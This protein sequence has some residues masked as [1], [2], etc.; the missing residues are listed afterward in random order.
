MATEADRYYYRQMNKEEQGAYHAMREGFL[1]LS[2][3][4]IVPALPM[5]TLASIFFRLRLDEPWIFYVET[6][7][8]R[9]AQGA[10]SMQLIP[11]YIYDRKKIPEHQKALK[12]RVARLV[13]QAAGLK[14]DQ[15]KELFIHDFICEHVTYD[16]LKKSYSHEITGPLQ[17]GVSVCE[18]IAKTVKVLCDELKI[19]CIIALCDSDPEHGYK[20]RHV[21][22]VIKIQGKWYHMDATFDNSLGRYGMK[23]YDYFNLDDK[24]NFRDHRPVMHP[25]PAC[26]DGASFYY[27]VNRLSLTKIEDVEKRLQTAIRKK[28]AHYIFHWRGGYLTKEVLLEIVKKAE[29][30]ASAKDKYLTMSFNWPQAVIAFHLYD[31]ASELPERILAEQADESDAEEKSEQT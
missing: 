26:T 28:Q 18:G 14:S 25:V 2:Q 20:Y 17:Q 19:P 29:E 13:R 21:W 22:N 10:D 8:C 15:E 9:H 11:S 24:W 23:R 31:S 30:V 1:S 16:K 12:S 3:Q 4:V 5:K 27:K 7:S 6:F